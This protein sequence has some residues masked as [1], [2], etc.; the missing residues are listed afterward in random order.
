VLKC[1]FEFSIF[2]VFA[3]MIKM[4]ELRGVSHLVGVVRMMERQQTRGSKHLLVMPQR[5]GWSCLMLK[6]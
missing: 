3:G 4:G 2:G 1:I 5:N 6:G